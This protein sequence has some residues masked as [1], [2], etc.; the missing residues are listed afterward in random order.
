MAVPFPRPPVSEP[1]LG[2]GEAGLA[3][4]TDPQSP[5][6]AGPREGGDADLVS[7]CE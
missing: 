5:V 3:C 6:T 4:V 2:L 1:F 7:C